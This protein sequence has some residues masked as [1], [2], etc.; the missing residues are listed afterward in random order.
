MLFS[1]SLLG[2]QCK[3]KCIPPPEHS[4]FTAY[5]HLVDEHVAI[6]AYRISSTLGG[7]PAAE[8]ARPAPDPRSRAR[9]HTS[10]C[11]RNSP[12]AEHPANP[13]RAWCLLILTYACSVKISTRWMCVREKGCWKWRRG[14]MTI[15]GKFP[16]WTL[17][18]IFW[19]HLLLLIHS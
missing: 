4:I 5:S 17:E 1:S 7:A 12:P 16:L 2:R 13:R 3:V 9:T 19:C 11:V 10:R 15:F 18:A 14:G 6:F 8:I